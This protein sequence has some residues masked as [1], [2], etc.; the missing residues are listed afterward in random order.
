MV[1]HEENRVE[2]DQ[3][4][5]IR[6]VMID[7][8]NDLNLACEDQNRRILHLAW[9]LRAARPQYYRAIEEAQGARDNRQLVRRVAS[10]SN[11]LERIER[12]LEQ[13]HLNLTGVKYELARQENEFYHLLAKHET[14]KMKREYNIRHLSMTLQCLQNQILAKVRITVVQPST[15]M[16]TR[17][18]R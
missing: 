18:G 6:L 16:L 14:A 10:T 5:S 17:I 15:Y 13:D 2:E 4:T 11:K 9:K 3:F 8:R 7:Q 12:H 1:A